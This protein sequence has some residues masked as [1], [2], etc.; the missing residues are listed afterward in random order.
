MELSKICIIHEFPKSLKVDRSNIFQRW[1]LANF[2]QLPVVDTKEVDVPVFSISLT[3]EFNL[4]ECI[5]YHPV[6][7]GRSHA[8]AAAHG[9]GRLE[10]AYRATVDAMG[11]KLKIF[12]TKGT[13]ERPFVLY[14]NRCVKG[15]FQE[16]VG[17]R[18]Y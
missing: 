13:H 2:L 5:R 18:E 9:S 17:N 8:R 4:K 10:D 3:M 14:R 1:K 7:R 15:G 16:K 11:I 6:W 12:D